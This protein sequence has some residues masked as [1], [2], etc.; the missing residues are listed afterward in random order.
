MKKTNFHTHVYRCGHAKGDVIDYVNEAIKNNY[1]AI[2]I[3]DHGPL[4][5]YLFDRMKLEEVE[6]YLNDIELVKNKFQDKIKVYKSF[7]L[8]YFKE[9][10]SHYK[11]LK[12]KTDYLVLGHHYFDFDISSWHVLTKENLDSYYKK[13]VE[14]M[15]TGYFSFVAHPDLFCF[16]Y[17]KWDENCIK[18][19]EEICKASLELDIPLELNANGVRKGLVEKFEGLRYNY[20]RQEFWEIAKSY[21]VKVLVNSDCHFPHEFYDDAVKKS[22]E[23]ASEW[24]LN[25]LDYFEFK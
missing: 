15:R 13:M 24:G 10:D 1:E 12:E 7:E 14:A 20:P 9:F 6:D 2:G 21:G 16:R 8:E 11:K 23:L 4:P 17:P 25:L 18:A 3:S 22:V 5:D 19:T